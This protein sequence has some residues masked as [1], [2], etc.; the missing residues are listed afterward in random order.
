MATTA[1]LVGSVH[2]TIVQTNLNDNSKTFFDGN[3]VTT[4]L[5]NAL[6]PA[7]GSFSSTRAGSFNTAGAHDGSTVANSGYAYWGSGGT[8]ILTYT[9]AG[10]ATGYDIDSINTIYGWGDSRGRHAAQH[11]DIEITTVANATFT[12]LTSVDYDPFTDSLQGSSQVTITDDAGALATGVTGIKFVIR[13]DNGSEVGVIHEY[14]VIGSATV[15]PEPTTA[16]L[17]GAFGLSL[18]FRRRK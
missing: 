6:S 12:A 15:I 2:A 8:V 10:S 16:T 14:D 7:L 1:L 3:A 11:Y 13:S 5:I 18:L 9:L 17:L 4:D